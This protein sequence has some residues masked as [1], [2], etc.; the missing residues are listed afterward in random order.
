NNMPKLENGKTY[1]YRISGTVLG[2]D[3][4][5]T[6]TH[7]LTYTLTVDDTAPEI[8]KA[9]TY[10]E[11]GKILIKV[12]AK[13]NDKLQCFALYDAVYNEESGK[14]EDGEEFALSKSNL[15]SNKT[16]EDGTTEFVYDISDIKDYLASDNIFISAVDYAW[17]ES[18]LCLL[19]LNGKSEEESSQPIEESSEP[20]EE[21][22]SQPVE[23]SYEPSKEESSQPVEESSEPSEEESS[24][25]V[26]ESSEPS[27]EQSSQSSNSGSMNTG[28]SSPITLILIIMVS[29]AICIVVATK[30]KKHF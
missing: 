10:N 2:F 3:G 12:I 28:S 26:E 20:S 29:T 7:T 23:E 11:N 5:K 22:S 6:K 13:D 16:Y 8:V 27:M 18:D 9:T 19:N 25:P 21:E 15:I 30:R 14:F 1:T 4:L 17:N 24:Q